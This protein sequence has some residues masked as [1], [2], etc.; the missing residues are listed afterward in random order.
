M[1]ICRRNI[2]RQR[3][4]RF[5]DGNMDLHASDLL[6]AV[7]PALKEARR[8]AAASAIDD[9]CAWFRTI[10]AGTPPIAAQP[11]EQP[12]PEAEPGPTC[13]QSVQRAEGDVAQH[14]DR[15]PQKQTHQIAMTALR[16][17]APASGGFGPDRVGRLPSFAIASSSASTSSTKA[18]TSANASQEKS[19]RDGRRFLC[20]A[21][22]L[23]VMV[24]RLDGRLS[25]HCAQFN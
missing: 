15:P 3:H 14:S 16:N 6:S 19:V 2:D 12:A 23:L 18:S 22:M 13:E 11:V 20:S 10:S 24:I 5:V 4:A 7:N 1:P 8:R 25:G 17:A 21:S 9:D